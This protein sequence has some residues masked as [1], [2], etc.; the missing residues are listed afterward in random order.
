[1][2]LIFE[3][4]DGDAM[5]LFCILQYTISVLS[6]IHTSPINKILVSIPVINPRCDKQLNKYRLQ[7]YPRRNLKTALRRGRGWMLPNHTQT[8]PPPEKLKSK[9]FHLLINP[10]LTNTYSTE[11]IVWHISNMRYV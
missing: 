9:G 10:H 4:I 2:M 8:P 6:D 7:N 1:M 3:C 11:Y 5:S